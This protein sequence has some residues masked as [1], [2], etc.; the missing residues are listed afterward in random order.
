MFLTITLCTHAK[1][2]FCNR[3]DYLY[4]NAFG[5]KSPTKVYMP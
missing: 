4:K 5:V 1:L 3:V 2:D